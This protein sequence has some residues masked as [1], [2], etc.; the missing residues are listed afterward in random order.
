MSVGWVEVDTQEFREGRSVGVGV[1]R[2]KVYCRVAQG[3]RM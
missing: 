1:T 2:T 3:Y